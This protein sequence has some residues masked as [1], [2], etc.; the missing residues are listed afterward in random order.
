MLRKILSIGMALLCGALTLNVCATDVSEDVCDSGSLIAEQINF[1]STNL[2]TLVLRSFFLES[3]K[4][5]RDR[6]L[7]EKFLEVY[8]KVYCSGRKEGCF[9]KFCTRYDKNS[10]VG[11]ISKTLEDMEQISSKS[12]LDFVAMK[13]PGGRDRMSDLFRKFINFAGDHIIGGLFIFFENEKWMVACT[14]YFWN[15]TSLNI[16]DGRSVVCDFIDE[17]EKLNDRVSLY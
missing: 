12:C 1:K 6:N 2:H 16:C 8:P 3:S 9:L 7:K 13:K 17:F 5:I 4:S 11:N 10:Y 14:P 15:S